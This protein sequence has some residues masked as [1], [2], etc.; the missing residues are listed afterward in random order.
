MGL[1]NGYDNQFKY[2]TQKWWSKEEKEI[3]RLLNKYYIK[4]EPEEVKIEKVIT[5][6]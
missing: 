4:P 5:N 3:I 2:L 1:I 6:L